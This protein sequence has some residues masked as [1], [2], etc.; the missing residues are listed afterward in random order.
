MLDFRHALLLLIAADCCYHLSCFITPFS[1]MYMPFR[2]FHAGF[3]S[4]LSALISCLRYAVLQSALRY[5]AAADTHIQARY[6]MMRAVLLRH[7]IAVSVAVMTYIRRALHARY[8]FSP[9]DATRALSWRRRRFVCCHADTRHSDVTPCYVY[10]TTL[11]ARRFS[12]AT[13]IT[14]ALCC[15]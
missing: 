3:L 12:L 2:C 4:S 9:A 13:L 14:R 5:V 7:V 11:H 6:A 8:G 10:A 1:L 15:R